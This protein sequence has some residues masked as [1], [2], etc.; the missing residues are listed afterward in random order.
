MKA[1]PE[2]IYVR[3]LNEG[4][5]VWRPVQ[6]VRDGTGSFMIVGPVPQ[7]E[8]ETWEFPLGALVMCQS[9]RF[10]DNSEGLAAEGGSPHPRAR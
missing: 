2:Q 4:V 3:L 9:R 10:G 5:E 1:S 8:G 7:P 6:A